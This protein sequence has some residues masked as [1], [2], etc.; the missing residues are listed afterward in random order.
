MTNL[1]SK[2][3]S[4]W[5]RVDNVVYNLGWKFGFGGRRLATNRIDIRVTGGWAEGEPTPQEEEDAFC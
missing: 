5:H 1:L 3:A 4:E 2:I